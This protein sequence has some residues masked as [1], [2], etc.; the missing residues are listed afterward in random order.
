M[1][2]GRRRFLQLLGGSVAAVSLSTV[3]AD[4]PRV[5]ML[6]PATSPAAFRQRYRAF[7]AGLAELGY[8]ENRN[9]LL[10]LRVGEGS[11][12]RLRALAE[13]LARLKVDLIVAF[14]TPASQAAKAATSTIPIVGVG[15]GDPVASGLIQSLARP[16]GNLTGTSN[17]S[18]PLVVVV[19]LKTARGMRVALAPTF[20]PA[21]TG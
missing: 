21:R 9:L 3:R 1:H 20:L 7:F 2:S 10:E 18:P 6:S 17:L 5:G 8:V 11:Y 4:S 13:E 14:G 19:N 15:I 16:G 12:E